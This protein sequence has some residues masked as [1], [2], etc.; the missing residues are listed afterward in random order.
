MLTWLKSKFLT[1]PTGNKPKTLGQL[2][3]EFAQ[4]AYQK[5]GFKIIAANFFNRTGLRLGEIDFIAKDRKKIIFV[6]VKT[7][8][9]ETDRFG[10]AVE[11]VNQ[12]KQIKLLKAVKMFLLRYPK[13][14]ALEPRIDVCAV[15]ANDF[16]Q[17]VLAEDKP[18]KYV[19]KCPVDKLNFSAKIISN[20]VEDWN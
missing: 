2:G 16:S 10:T 1:N 6:E 9:Q 5:R 14:A 3:E 15:I 18:P 12:F 13:Y 20:A 8:K 19:A 17:L 11:A 4:K 7:R